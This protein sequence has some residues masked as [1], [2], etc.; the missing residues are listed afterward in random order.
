MTASVELTPG[1]A[2]AWFQAMPCGQRLRSLSP[3]F[4]Q[5]DTR[6]AP[7]LACVHVGFEQGTSRWLHTLHLREVPG[8]GWAAISPYG[9]G[10]PLCNSDEPAFVEKAWSA[11]QAWARNRSVLGEFCR[12]HPETQQQRYFLGDVRANRAT[13]SID[14]QVQPL[15]S[16]FNTLARRKLKRAAQVPVRW[17]RDAQDWRTFGDF[18]RRAMAAMGA[19]ERYHFGDAYFAAIAALEGVELCICG[20]GREWLS[21]GVYLFQQPGPQDAGPGGTLEYHLG[22]SSEAG[23]ATGTAYRLQ[24]AAALEGAARGLAHLYLGGGT[25]TDDDNPLLFYKRAFSR[26]ERTFHVGNAVHHEVLY[27]AFAQSRGYHRDSAPPNLLFD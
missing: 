13:V 27:G 20:E 6:R 5:A 1:E 9:Y 14:L 26:R 4:G 18:Y 12:F 22:A 10:G 21:A 3:D 7:G 15:E 19:H 23:H 16:Q 8:F 2:M 24:H 25:S 11:Y 17:S